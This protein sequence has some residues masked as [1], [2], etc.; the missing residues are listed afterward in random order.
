MYLA[1]SLQVRFLYHKPEIV[2]AQKMV[3]GSLL[4]DVLPSPPWAGGWPVVMDCSILRAVLTRSAYQY[5]SVGT[6][7]SQSVFSASH[8]LQGSKDVSGSFLFCQ[9]VSH[10]F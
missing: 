10:A 7:A 9:D 6:L 8:W 2:S 5:L 4:A 3:D 1:A